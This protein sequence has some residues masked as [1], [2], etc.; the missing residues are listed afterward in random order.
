M[1]EI[2]LNDRVL[3][4]VGG[5]YYAGKVIGHPEMVHHQLCRSIEFDGL[6]KDTPDTGNK[7]W[8]IPVDDIRLEPATFERVAEAIA[9]AGLRFENVTAA[10]VGVRGVVASHEARG[11]VLV[12]RA[13]G[14][15]GQVF[16]TFCTIDAE[17]SS[18]PPQPA[19]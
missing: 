4:K 8:L 12:G 5:H 7:W 11:W 1:A 9:A 17:Q 3:C 18:A 2:Q 16:L 6:R 19:G 14:N 10:T 13:N 15:R